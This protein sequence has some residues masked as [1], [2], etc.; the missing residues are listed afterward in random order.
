MAGVFTGQRL[1]FGKHARGSAHRLMHAIENLEAASVMR[2]N[3][4]S[5]RRLFFAFGF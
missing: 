4:R 2:F 1:D 3:F 5:Q